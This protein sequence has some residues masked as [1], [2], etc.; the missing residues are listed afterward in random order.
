[1]T[2][3]SP[4]K[5]PAADLRLQAMFQAFDDLMF[6]LEEDGTIIDF[7]A[8]EGAP[9]YMPSSKFLGRK[10][11]EAFPYKAGRKFSDALF[12]LR[13]ERKVHLLEYSLFT[14]SGEF[15]YESRLVPVGNHQII[16]FVR[17]ITRYKLAETRARSQL[18]QLAALRDIDLAITSD[19]DLS[20]TLAIILD[21]VRRRLGIDAAAILLINPHSQLLEFA[22]DA[23]FL[24]PALQHTQ[25]RLG[26]GYAGQAIASRKTVHVPNLRTRK[27]DL[28]RSPFFHREN[29]AEYYAVPFLVKGQAL[30]VLEIFHRT[31]IQADARWVDFMNVLAGQAAIAIDN[32]MLLKDLEA[33]N[34][35]LSAAYEKTIEGWAHALH[36]RDRETDVHTRRVT[37]MTV[38]LARKV[39][40]P[41]AQMVHIRRGAI[42]HDIGKVAIPDSI[43]LKPGP[44]DET[45]WAQM[46]RH[47]FIATEMLR[48]IAYLEPALPIPGSHHEKWDGS[49][50]PLGLSREQIPIEARAFAF[51]DV[52]DAL[53]S[54][55]PYRTAWTQAEAVDYIR[56]QDGK[57]FD[58]HITPAFMELVGNG[59]KM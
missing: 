46:R 22:A 14:S 28:L 13:A 19:M 38:S 41:E 5:V 21:H 59:P 55:R 53:T 56:A 26:E 25:L 57:Q 45:E 39:G 17:D 47:P 23:G 10:I 8:G 51:A 58:P 9:Y 29:F 7:K 24:T 44:L 6:V 37:E 4:Q 16:V 12:S 11:Q 36:L 2:Q 15:W 20:Q 30:G 40:L 31:Q 35:D 32:A 18:E 50:Y 43:L 52:Y 48:P 42:L 27:T 1:M 33:T 3:L 54:D 49:G 34:A